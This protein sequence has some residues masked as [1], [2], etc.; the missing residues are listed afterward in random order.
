M[1]DQLAANV[2]EHQLERQELGLNLGVPHTQNEEKGKEETEEAKERQSKEEAFERR[3]E[4]VCP[5][6]FDKGDSVLTPLTPFSSAG[7]G[8]I[9]GPVFRTAGLNFEQLSLQL[10]IWPKEKDAY[11]SETIATGRVWDEPIVKYMITSLRQELSRTGKSGGIVID[12]GANLGQFSMFAAKLGLHVYSFEPVNE[13]VELIQRSAALNNVEDRVSVFHYALADRHEQVTIVGPDHNQGAGKVKDAKQVSN[14]TADLRL[15]NTAKLDDLIHYRQVH[16]P[17]LD[18]FKLDVE[19]YE[20]YVLRGAEK[21]LRTYA[22]KFVALEISR[23]LRLSGCDTVL[24]LR[25]L[26]SLGYRVVDQ[27]INLNNVESWVQSTSNMK[28]VDL[29]LERSD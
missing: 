14:N 8:D 12:A 5:S 7:E 27:D 19:G 24:M 15:I 13:L 3:F 9:C 4:R 28:T 22:I 2:E 10:C 29:L 1:R 17:D 20:A 18:F 23:A 21:L 26:L 11:I 25:S 16:H 6:S